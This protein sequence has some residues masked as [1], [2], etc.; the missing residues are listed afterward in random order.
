MVCDCRHPL[1]S[2]PQRSFCCQLVGRTVLGALRLRD[3]RGNVGA[4][5]RRDRLHP[6]FLRCAR[7]LPPSNACNIAGTARAP[8]VRREG[9]RTHC[10]MRRSVCFAPTVGCTV[11]GAPWPRDRRGGLGAPVRRDRQHPRHPRRARLASTAQ[12]IQS[13]GHSPRTIFYGRTKVVRQPTPG[14]RGSPPLRCERVGID[15]QPTL[16]VIRRRGVGDAAPYGRQLNVGISIAVNRCVNAAS[17]RPPP[18][19]P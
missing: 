8:F 6:C 15:V 7:Q 12:R 2:M 1:R 5:G 4:D 18:R 19:L 17:L 14:G 10:H 9:N 3:C 16:S 13:R 11:L